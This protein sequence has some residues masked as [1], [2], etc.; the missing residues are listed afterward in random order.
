[1]AKRKIITL[2]DEKLRMLSK[3]V[4][5]FDLRLRLLLKDLTQT[6]YASNG[7]GLA[8]PQVG[9]LKRVI[10]VDT[11][12]GSG[13]FELVN[14]EIAYAEGEQVDE[15]GCLSIPGRAGIVKRPAKIVVKAQDFRGKPVEIN[16]E[17]F[18]ARAL[19]HEIDHLD[20]IMYIDKMEHELTQEELAARNKKD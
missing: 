17:G 19:C 5:S 7:V 20:G 16:A 14:P 12:D 18:L 6:M 15:E 8:A 3:P 9:I 11:K 10:V 13:L 4:S 2:G 1:M